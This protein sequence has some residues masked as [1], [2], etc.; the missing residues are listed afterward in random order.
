MCPDH[1]I[2]MPNPRLQAAASAG[3]GAGNAEN[4][5]VTEIKLP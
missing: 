5:E 1:T 2:Q 4:Y 3:L